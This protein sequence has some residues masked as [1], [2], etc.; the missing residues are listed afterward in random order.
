[1]R[2]LAKGTILNQSPALFQQLQA[3]L[4]TKKQNTVTTK[5][6]AENLA[7]EDR[8]KVSEVEGPK[9]QDGRVDHCQFILSAIGYAVGL[10]NVWRFPYVAYKNGGGSFLIPY[11]L[12]LL[13]A[14][15]PLFFME[16]AL[17]QYAGQ[18]VTR[19]YGNL[20]PAFKGLGFAMLTGTFYVVIYYN[21]LTAWSLFYLFSGFQSTLP[22]TTCTNSSSDHCQPGKINSTYQLLEDNYTVGPAEDYFNHEMLGLDR[23]VHNWGNFGELRW[24]LVLCLLA[25]WTIVCLCLIKGLQSAGK[26]IYFTGT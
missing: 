25:A 3:P 5:N 6:M 11:T 10:G 23:E 14:G 9:P 22:W 19:V 17:G 20:A 7:S 21:V 18:G 1:M 13:F 4:V 2:L 15:L 8:K 12:M 26:A 24:Q 16:L